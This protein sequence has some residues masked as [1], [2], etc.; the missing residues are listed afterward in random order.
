MWQ[1]NL[2]KPLVSGRSGDDG[3]GSGLYRS[4]QKL[5]DSESIIPYQNKFLF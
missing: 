5:G 1:D 3:M 2:T 4:A